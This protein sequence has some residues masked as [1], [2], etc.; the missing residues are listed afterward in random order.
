MATKKS[1]Q[2]TE[3]IVKEKA[4]SVEKITIKQYV[5]MR[6]LPIFMIEILGNYIS[7]N[8][9]EGFPKTVVKTIE[10]WDLIYNIMNNIRV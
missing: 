7:K 8:E 1:T 9:G 6:N 3:P 4:N 5:K 10:Q 2:K